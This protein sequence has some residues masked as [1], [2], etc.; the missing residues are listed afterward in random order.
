MRCFAEYHRNEKSTFLDHIF[1]FVYALKEWLLE[2]G[3]L[4]LAKP[5]KGGTIALVEPISISRT[6]CMSTL[7]IKCGALAGKLANP[8]R[9]ALRTIGLPVI[10]D[11]YCKK[12]QRD[13]PHKLRRKV[14]LTCVGVDAALNPP[15]KPVKV[16]V[17]VP[18]KLVAE[19]WDSDLYVSGKLD[20]TKST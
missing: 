18:Q 2:P 20:M 15:L 1:I 6:L 11:K 5:D 13:L 4:N 16:F 14:R 9:H 19:F 10:G 7:K 12:E 3:Q 8:I 17:D